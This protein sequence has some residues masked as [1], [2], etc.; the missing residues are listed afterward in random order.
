MIETDFLSFPTVVAAARHGCFNCGGAL[1]AASVCASG[2]APRRG[3]YA[4]HCETCGISTF[5]DLAA[6][7]ARPS[8]D[9]AWRRERAD[10]ERTFGC[11]DGFDS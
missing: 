2:N 11:A 8:A 4:M 10:T 3:A 7:D 5:F 1:P 6:V 9:P